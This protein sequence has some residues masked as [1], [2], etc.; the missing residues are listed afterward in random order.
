MGYI[1]NNAMQHAYGCIAC[2]HVQNFSDHSTHCRDVSACYF[3]GE[4]DIDATYGENPSLHSVDMSKYEYGE[5]EHSNV[6]SSCQQPCFAQSHTG[7][8]AG[9][10]YVIAR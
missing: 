5:Y 2:G 10:P 4:T 7:I 1:A 8:C 6:C 3:C 9:L